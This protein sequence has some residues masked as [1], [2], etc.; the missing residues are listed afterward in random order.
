MLRSSVYISRVWLYNLLRLNK[1]SNTN[2]TYTTYRSQYESNNVYSDT[3]FFPVLSAEILKKKRDIGSFENRLLNEMA[4]NELDGEL[5]IK[6]GV[7]CN[8]YE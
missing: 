8:Y 2:I 6:C 3:G 1:Y 4:L 5:K 7:L